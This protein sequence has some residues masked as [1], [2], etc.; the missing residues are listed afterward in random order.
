M[1]HKVLIVDDDEDIRESLMDFLAD[2]GYSPVGATDGRDALNKLAAEPSPCVIILD[3]MM[4]VLDGTGF[5]KQQLRNPQLSAIPVIVVSAYG[6]ASA[7]AGALHGT[8]QL[9]KPPDLRA[10]LE[11][12]RTHCDRN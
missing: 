10:L 7:Y 1:T 6:D 9:P 4:P 2:H 8:T 5:R 12:M 11:I 3:L